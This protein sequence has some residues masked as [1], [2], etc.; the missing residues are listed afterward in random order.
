MTIYQH[1]GSVEE[2]CACERDDNSNDTITAG[3]TTG[4]MNEGGRY[5]QDDSTVC[6]RDGGKQEND[7]NTT[8]REG[9][10]RQLL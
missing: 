4:V 9:T 7:I 5:C 6:R 3:T 2:R 1:D 10:S 8:A